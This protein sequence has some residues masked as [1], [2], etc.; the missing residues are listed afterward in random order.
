MNKF[1]QLIEYVI[2]DEEA[3]AQELF[4]EIVVE[5]SRDIYENIM[6]EEESGL[7]AKKVQA[8]MDR[9]EELMDQ[10]EEPEDAQDQAA[11]EMGVDPE[12]LADYLDNMNEG[13]EEEL[14]GSQAG[15]LIDDIEA[16]E[17]G[18]S[19]EAED[20]EDEEMIDVDMETGPS[21]E[22]EDLEDRVVDLEDKLDELMGE[23]EQLMNTVDTDGD[24]DHD[25]DDHEDEQEEMTDKEETMDVEIDDEMETE[26]MHS[27]KRMMDDL[28]ENVSLE[29]AP[30]PTTSEQGADAKSPV[31]ANSGA[32]GMDA[33]PVSTDQTDEK[34]RKAPQAKDMGG[35]TKPN[36]QSAPKP[37][38]SQAS[39]VNDKSPY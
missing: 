36:M 2:N 13:I 23:F 7:D 38:T 39:G 30:K 9:K 33:K 32:K 12:D 27:K 20:M 8:I 14:G 26:M 18:M 24:G 25:M 4:H 5:K 1:E 37:T 19:L 28:E 6:A 3:K 16:E 22:D 17:E 10:G 34:G 35:T 21:D 11:E 31:A 29:A 15:D